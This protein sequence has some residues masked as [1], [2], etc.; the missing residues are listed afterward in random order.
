MRE[1][2]CRQGVIAMKGRGAEAAL[3]ACVCASP[4]ALAAGGVQYGGAGQL[5]IS[6]A[7]GITEGALPK[8]KRRGR[9]PRNRIT[10]PI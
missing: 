7:S 6:C 10:R 3:I 5:G 9:T 2:Y 8:T 4:C 1:S